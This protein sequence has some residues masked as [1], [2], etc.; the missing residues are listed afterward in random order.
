M[1]T[2]KKFYSIG[3]IEAAFTSSVNRV[4]SRM[5]N[6]AEV[7]KQIRENIARAKGYMRR[8]EIPRA[9]QAAIDALTL[10]GKIKLIGAARFE[11]EVNLDEVLVDI[12]RH[13]EIMPLLPPGKNGKPFL[14]RFVRGKEP[15]LAT[16]LNRVATSLVEAANR[17]ERERVEKI[18]RHKQ[19]LMH[20]GQ[21]FLDGGDLPKARSFFRRAADEFGKI[22]G[23]LLD[24]AERYHK[25]DH[26]LEAAEIYE[27]AMDRFPRDPAAYSGAIACYMEIREYEK[28]ERIY[29]FVLRQ[30]GPHPRTLCNMAKFYMLWR[31]KEKAADFAYRALKRDSS[32]VEAQQIL[33]ELE[34][35]HHQSAP[36]IS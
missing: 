22:P 17:E 25:A 7:A 35:R 9:L 19:E 2:D 1:G 16:V 21:F 15:L 6:T 27:M 36:Q 3:R 18:E 31:K 32:L 10:Y 20:H 12:S 30:F 14:L 13:G 5:M 23:L 34:G 33:D 24:I 29:E 8:D 11:I 26:P 28:V 4:T